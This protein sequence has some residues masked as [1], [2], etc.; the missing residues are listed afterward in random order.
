MKI[1]ELYEK[2]LEEGLEED[3]HRI[4]A[5]AYWMADIILALPNDPAFKKLDRSIREDIERIVAAIEI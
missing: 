2:L 3:A 5:H 4:A 1:H